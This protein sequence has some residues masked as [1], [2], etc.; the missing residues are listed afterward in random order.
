MFGAG[1]HRCADSRD[2]FGQ[3]AVAHLQ[4]GSRAD[5]TVERADGQTV[6]GQPFELGHV[7]AARIH[8]RSVASFA[9]RSADDPRVDEAY[10]GCGDDAGDRAHG[11]RRDGVA[12][13]IQRRRGAAGVCGSEA[14]G[15]A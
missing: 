13:D 5:R 7:R 8:V 2:P 9:R 15:H 6:G 1:E 12:V 14:F 11:L 10:A 3:S 4:R